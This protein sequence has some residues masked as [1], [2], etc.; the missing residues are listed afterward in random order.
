M[1]VTREITGYAVHYPD[2]RL[3]GVAKYHG[4]GEIWAQEIGGSVS[5]APDLTLRATDGACKV[6]SP[7]LGV[8]GI[9]TQRRCH[10]DATAMS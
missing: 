3:A 7:G 9:V 8:I 4:K 6:C 1:N 2:G 10:A 5:D